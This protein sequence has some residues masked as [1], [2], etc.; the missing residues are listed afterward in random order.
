MSDGSRTSRGQKAYLQSLRLLQVF[1]AAPSST[2]MREW[3]L[4]RA[5]FN[6]HSGNPDCMGR[7]DRLKQL[8]ADEQYLALATAAQLAIKAMAD[9]RIAIIGMGT[10]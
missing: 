8:A 3:L 5:E 7:S 4:A 2:S 1:E 9:R 6:E 10:T